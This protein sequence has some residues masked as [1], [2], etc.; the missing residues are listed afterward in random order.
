MTRLQNGTS[1][2]GAEPI[3][4]VGFAGRWPGASTSSKLEELLF[5]GRSGKTAVPPW[6]FNVDGFYHESSKRAG[7]VNQKDGYYLPHDPKLFDSAFFGINPA[8]AKT[9]DPA[10][11]QLLEVAYECFESAG[12][13]LQD[14]SR[15]KTGCFVGNHG[16]EFAGHRFQD[17][18]FATNTGP[19]GVTGCVST[20]LS[21][22]ELIPDIFKILANKVSFTIDTACS[23][24]LY[25][26]HTAINSL[27]AGDCGAALVAGVNLIF[28]AF[29]Q[30]DTAS[31]GALSPTATCHT[32]DI[33]ADGYG[34]A[35]GVGALYIKR[36]S[37]AI[38]DGDSIRAIVRGTAI[39][40]NGKTGGVTYPS[41]EG[42]EAVIRAAYAKAGI[43]N[44]GETGYFECHGTGT[45]VGDPLEIKAIGKVF[46]ENRTPE[47]PL[48]V[49]SIKTNIGHS[50]SSSGMSALFKSIFA[51]ETGIIP[52]TIGVKT[53]NPKIDF[54]GSRVQVV[55]SRTSLP[56][57]GTFGAMRVSINNFGFGGANGHAI[58]EATSSYLH[59]HSASYIHRLPSTLQNGITHIP[60]DPSTSPNEEEAVP[61][62]SIYLLPFSAHDEV[63]LR[64]NISAVKAV[65]SR[66]NPADLAYTLAKRTLLY[67]R[68]FLLMTDG[69]PMGDPVCFGST[70]AARL[71]FV[72]TGQGAQW[73]GMGADLVSTFPVFA[74][75]ISKLDA[76]LRSL[77]DGPNWN[78]SE[79]LCLT[80][81]DSRVNGADVAQPLCTAL[82]IAVVDLLASWGVRP[83]A[84]VG[85]SSGEIAASYAAGFLTDE[86]ALIIAYYRG[87]VAKSVQTDGAML[88]VGLGADVV[89][90]YIDGLSAVRIACV[91]SPSSVTLSGD[92]TV[93]EEVLV[94]LQADGV[95]ARL[96]KTDG[97]A[98]HSHHMQQVGQKYEDLI[99]NACSDKGRLD[100]KSDVLMMSSVTAKPITAVMPMSY[101]RKNLESPVLFSQAVA[102]IHALDLVDTLVEIGP[103]SALEGPLRQIRQSSEASAGYL[104]TLT[105]NQSSSR[106]LLQLC[107]NLFLKGASID[108]KAIH[109]H[110]EYYRQAGGNFK[111]PK[112]IVDLPSYQWNH[113]TVHW[114]ESTLSTGYR[115]RKHPRHDLLGTRIPYGGTATMIWRNL[116]R[117]KDLP[118]IKDHQIQKQ[119]LF[120][121]AGYI[122][123]VVEAALQMHE[124]SGGSSHGIWF[125]LRKIALESGLILTESNGREMMLTL[126]PSQNSNTGSSKHWLDFK[127]LSA[128]KGSDDW[129][130]HCNGGISVETEAF[131]ELGY[132]SEAE[133]RISSPSSIKQ[134]SSD[135]AYKKMYDMGLCYGPSFRRLLDLNWDS[136]SQTISGHTNIGGAMDGESRYAIHPVGL[137]TGLQ[138]STL[139]MAAGNIDRLRGHL[140]VFIEK[141]TLVGAA[142]SPWPS[143]SKAQLAGWAKKTGVRS[144]SG[145]FVVNS[146]EA[147]LKLEATG[148]KM[149]EFENALSAGTTQAASSRTPYLRVVYKPD[150][151]KLSG[152]QFQAARSQKGFLSSIFE[153]PIP[154]SGRFRDIASLVDLHAFKNSDMNIL[155]IGGANIYH[156]LMA[157]LNAS[158][159]CPRF[160]RY[161]LVSSSVT[162][163]VCKRYN[164]I[165]LY[166]NSDA[167]DDNEKFNLIIMGSLE[168]TSSKDFLEATRQRLQPGGKVIVSSE[169]LDMQDWQTSSLEEVG[170]ENNY[171]ATENYV[172]FHARNDSLKV[173]DEKNLIIV[174]RYASGAQV[175][176]QEQ[177]I[178]VAQKLGW[179]VS[180][181]CLT[182]VKVPV[183]SNVL[184][185][186]DLAK[187]SPLFETISTAELE[188]L[189]KITANA[190]SVIWVTTDGEKGKNPA[191]AMMA[192]WARSVSM[193][194]PRLSFVTCDLESLNTKTTEA[195]ECL[196]DLMLEHFFTHPTPGNPIPI[197]EREYQ[198]INGCLYVPRA[199]P[200]TVEN[201][202][203]NA[204]SENA[205]KPLVPTAIGSQPVRMELG[206][207]GQLDSLYFVEDEFAQKPLRPNY[208]EIEVKAAGMNY[209]DV[210]I[211]QGMFDA[212]MPEGSERPYFFSS[213][214]AGVVTRVGSEVIGL[215]PGDRVASVWGGY[216]ATHERVPSYTCIKLAPDED[217]KE[218]TSM[219]IVYSTAIYAFKYLA[220]LEEGESVLIH[221]GAGGVGVAAITLAKAMGAKVYT[222]VS[223][224]E[225]RQF[226]KEQFGISDDCIFYSR[227][228]SF[229]KDIKKATNGKGVDVILSPQAGDL[230]R[231]SWTNCLANFG[232]YIDIGRKDALDHGTLDM[233]PMSR[234]C[235]FHSFDMEKI[236][237]GSPKLFEKLLGDLITLYRNGTIAPIKPI[238][239][240]PVSDLSKALR[241][242]MRGA[243][244]GKFVVDYTDPKTEVMCRPEV[245]KSSVQFDPN[246]TYIIVG[247]L[248]GLGR[249]L[250]SW[251]QEK[252][253]RNFMLMS[254]SGDA[255]Y[256]DEAKRL[257][258]KT[259]DAG[260]H[261]ITLKGDATKTE[262]V[263]RLM[264]TAASYGPI[265]GVVNSAMIVGDKL[266]SKA[267][268][269]DVRAIVNVKHLATRY[270]HQELLNGS[271]T[272]EFFVTLSSISGTVGPITQS[273]YAAANAAQDSFARFR[274][275]AGLPCVSLALGAIEEVGHLEEHS[276]VQDKFKRM[277]LSFMNQREFLQ[278]M[279]VAIRLQN[280][281]LTPKRERA[282]AAD[283]E[284]HGYLLCGL[285]TQNM[286]HLMAKN[287]S[288]GTAVMS[289]LKFS[290][291][292]NALRI[293][294]TSSG[295][296][297]AAAA[298]TAASAVLKAVQEKGKAAGMSVLMVHFVKKLSTLL[299]LPEGQFDAGKSLVEY[300]MDSMI[301]SELRAYLYAE[302]RIDVSFLEISMP[303]RTIRDM[304]EL[305]MG[306]MK[307]E[308]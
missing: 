148:V 81:K 296:T 168:E 155:Q 223:N 129:V 274:V 24:S 59:E 131:E 103:H 15:S 70:K 111:A 104:S 237:T 105:R 28:G 228:R 256:D 52:A 14:L 26:L 50:E 27:E 287:F 291:L 156:R 75:T 116:L 215:A 29:G 53:L 290:N 157:I 253:A 271:H 280:P 7:S 159:N 79:I 184:C 171:L 286:E 76:T 211:A 84:V 122:C 185:L 80:D 60:V 201:A 165:Q 46:A 173:S 22:R 41:P 301:G 245:K 67:Q 181:A 276:D 117:L 297:P 221:S 213:E 139:V 270:L 61:K 244:S 302:F 5:N 277:G 149:L 231:E 13:S 248:G 308:S 242:F 3:A 266:F 284:S 303:T 124:L 37:D 16:F 11:R 99:T 112:L 153:N 279:E 226:L 269:S 236:C 39:N 45:P 278:A 179:N 220:H 158:T 169:I 115:F 4:I 187:D 123:M 63:S 188:G 258:K 132:S 247:G 250:I 230:M 93:I 180:E 207:A 240:F 10:Q 251:M 97:K 217:F 241:I 261:L 95:F 91:N 151:D 183:D 299:L 94:K 212:S 38:R 150:I 43:R 225:K 31:L 199:L 267:T 138:L 32:F 12:V 229:V 177:L 255:R 137:D 224:D 110:R 66:Y 134:V 71:A 167:I 197:R 135:A 133:F 235:V 96:L 298:E 140:P 189:Q 190:R 87:V 174:D 56:R 216:Y 101:W 44:F 68:S 21:N 147:G 19:Y 40:A 86:Q 17:Q 64:A 170:Y 182:D 120:P 100:F 82:Q 118:W 34:R 273:V 36:L 172:V 210:V 152:E 208:V 55:T 25:A 283:P 113:S 203:F 204:G 74:R 141:L 23:G 154:S 6:S 257:A 175:P 162:E 209:K 307:L 219:T 292:K 73:P 260:G 9:M 191:G 295:A 300:G 161:S 305:I 142:R 186:V 206:H 136:K 246:G 114:E 194:E 102:N 192:A 288:G 304:A 85:H 35:E 119:V 130:Q 214:R 238:K 98:Y 88:A 65:A 164:Q 289:D 128:D 107:G 8:E 239:V 243:H 306:R 48:F 143:D 57:R 259:T 51:L 47:D 196:H 90:S 2:A 282:L 178:R 285:D 160:W 92:R 89:K 205:E 264:E 233:S 49:G 78:I 33:A 106:C 144:T 265:K 200:D 222:T 198:Q 254:R 202:A 281:Q 166:P 108:L 234:D 77:P 58:L 145:G 249:A 218:M 294:T 272:P 62:Q 72:F 20:L 227:D 263:A 121:A 18:D 268:A 275:A 193:E 262:D 195:V 163:S 109:D 127:I 42:Q 30:M 176:L 146:E 54:E 126:S 1:E 125:N 232:R 252:G 83:A 293:R 69:Q